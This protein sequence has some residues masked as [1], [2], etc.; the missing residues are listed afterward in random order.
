MA[1]QNLP[2]IITKIRRLNKSKLLLNLTVILVALFAC[3]VEDIYLFFLTPQSGETAVLTFRSQSSFAFDQEKAF[4]GL[5]N[6]SVARHIPIYVFV[7]NKLA[8]TKEKMEALI[9]EVSRDRSGGRTGRAAFI[10]YLQKEFGMEVSSRTAIRFLRSPDLKKIL[11]GFLT[12]QESVFQNKIVDDPEPLKGK[13]T[14]RVLYPDPVGLDTFP[15][16]EIT[17]LEKA[18]LNL[19][20]KVNQLFSHVDPEILSPFL[21]L[22]LAAL[23]PNLRYDQKENDRRY[24][25][26]IQQYPTK[27]ITFNPGDVIVPFRKVMN[28]KDV[29]LLAAAQETREKD[30]YGN[31]TWVLFVICFSVLLYNLYLLKIFSPYERKKPPYQLFLIALI[32]TILLFEVCLLFTPYP[33]YILPFAILPLVLVLL[34]QEKVSITFTTLLGAL[35][36]SLLSGRNLGIFLFFI[37]GGLVAILASFRIR[38]RSHIL[39]PSLVVGT[40]NALVVLLLSA[41]SPAPGLASWEA[42]IS[43]PLLGHMGWAFAGGLAAGPIVLL[44]LPLLELSWRNTSAFKLNKF[45][46]LQNPLMIEL[47]TKAP[48]TYQHVMSV[49]QLAYIL[50]EAVG[51]NSLLLRVA[52]YYHDIGKTAN[53][54]FFVENLF[55]RKSPHD[56]LPARES[57]IIIMDHVRDGKRIALEAGL[58][59]VVADFIPQHHGTR[60]IEYFY[61]KAVKENPEAEVS[62]KD[63][64]YSGPKPQSVEAAI[65]MIVDGVEATSRTMEEPSREKMEAMIRHTIVDRI[66]DGQF[67]ECNLSTQEIAKIIT[68]LVHSLEASFHTRVKYPWQQKEKDGNKINNDKKD[69]D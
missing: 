64:R 6:A 12:I 9:D 7:P 41:G 61:D 50:G 4:A 63:F 32:V 10:G 66:S 33:V 44:L 30:L 34:L 26:K 37:F 56:T 46:D 48:G 18:R 47:L 15:A 45:S 68:V 29:L 40:T 2:P 31:F 22:S 55:G 23:R 27:V 21:Q 14:V 58:P 62:Q 59:E 17:T 60:L 13:I 11:A 65:L 5:R 8:S 57:T 16:E 49:A 28:T 1:D 35:F 42:V 36:L 39:I 69:S 52:A 3:Y 51:A 19:R 25:E 20:E 67:D 43:S 38:K 54:D 24:K 53:P